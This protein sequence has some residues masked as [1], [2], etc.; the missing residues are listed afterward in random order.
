MNESCQANGTCGGGSAVTCPP[1][2]DQC[3]IAGVCAPASG[4]QPATVKVGSCTD[5]D[6]CTVAESCQTNGSCGGGSPA[7]QN[8]P[9]GNN[10]FCDGNRAC[11]CRQ[12][13]ASNRLTNP[14]L[15]GDGTGWEL[16]AGMFKANADADGCSGSGSILVQNTGAEFF[17][18]VPTGTSA[19]TH[20]Y[21]RY[22]YKNSQG[23][24]SSYCTVSFIPDNAGCFF[25]NVSNSGTWESSVSNG[26]DWVLGGSD[27]MTDA[28]TTHIM[29]RCTAV[30]GIG[31]YDQLY[32]STTVPP[33]GGF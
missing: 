3:H 32:L 20:Y 22:R 31:Y 10:R 4:C 9:C 26:T 19:P 8:T 2:A 11:K 21:F 13:S 1:A 15:D 30:I 25:E 28:G 12:P 7:P 14:G 16:G 29:L 24:G 27:G 18:C 33:A 17:Q 6:A 23:T 5:G